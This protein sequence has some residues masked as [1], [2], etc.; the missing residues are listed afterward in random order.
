M[1]F[2]EYGKIQKRMAELEALI[3]ETKKGFL[4]TPPSRL[5]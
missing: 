2:E 1:A 5:L 3:E 4:H